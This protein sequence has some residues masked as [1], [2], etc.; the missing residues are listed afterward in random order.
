MSEASE[1]REK[2]ENM[3]KRWVTIE[4]NVIDATTEMLGQTDN[5]VL[6]TL[7]DIMKRD[8]E[9]HKEIL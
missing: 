7:I 4:E 9:K 3:I 5:P 2:F 6:R 1:S 8:S